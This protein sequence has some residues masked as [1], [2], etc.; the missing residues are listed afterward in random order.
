MATKSKKP[1]RGGIENEVAQF[2][3]AHSGLP[4]AGNPNLVSRRP[5]RQTPFRSGSCFR[6]FLLTKKW[7]FMVSPLI[8]RAGI[9]EWTRWPWMQNLLLSGNEETLP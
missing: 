3:A 6:V 8:G 4:F 5:V 9:E 1:D 2:G 7:R